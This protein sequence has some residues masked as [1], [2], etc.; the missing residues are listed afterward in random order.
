MAKSSAG[1]SLNET[2]HKRSISYETP[3]ENILISAVA[4][5]AMCVPS[6]A[7]GQ[8]T[9]TI[10]G[11]VSR[12]TMSGFEEV[13]SVVKARTGLALGASVGIPIQDNLSLRLDGGYVQKGLHGKGDAAGLDINSDYIEFSGL[14][15][16]DLSKSGGSAVAYFFAGPSMAFL[17][18]CGP[19]DRFEHGESSASCREGS[20]SI[21]FGITGGTG[22]DMAV[23]EQMTLAVD[24]RYTLGLLS[25]DET[26]GDDVKNRNL[27]LQVG[28][29]FPIGE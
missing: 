4:L 22:A 16:V 5:L 10:R 12:A 15:V 8:T 14:G 3:I 7:N 23:S 24:L 20:R 13:E 29:G 27:I 19:S 26:G 21:D 11:G 28:V 2:I 1:S 17:A 9:F 6:T 25:I 18:S